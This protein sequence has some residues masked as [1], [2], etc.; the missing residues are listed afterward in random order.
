M[1][2]IVPGNMN[3]YFTSY[4][5]VHS[6]SHDILQTQSV[7]IFSL[8]I[9][10]QGGFMLLGGVFERKLGPRLTALLGGWTMR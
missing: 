7:W 6:Q 3:P 9:F 8:T 2:L 5:R 10:G 1:C 4:L